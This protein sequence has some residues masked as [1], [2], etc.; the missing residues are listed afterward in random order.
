MTLSNFSKSIS[1]LILIEIFLRQYVNQDW[2]GNWK[3]RNV[4]KSR[5]QTNILIYFTFVTDWRLFIFWFSL[6]RG[7]CCK[8]VVFQYEKNVHGF[9]I[10]WYSCICHIYN[11]REIA[12]KSVMFD[13]IE[14]CM[15][16]QKQNNLC[17]ICPHK[18]EWL[19]TNHIIYFE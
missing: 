7:F 11:T 1:K 16:I 13:Q 3:L 14:I 5:Y 2:V 8:C 6:L 10:F 19:S 15:D 12:T 9:Y 4:N 17:S 18:S